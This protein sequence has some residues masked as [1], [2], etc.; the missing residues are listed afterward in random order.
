MKSTT[1]RRPQAVT[2]ICGE[3]CLDEPVLFV[4]VLPEGTVCFHAVPELRTGTRNRA[5]EPL[6][7]ARP[8]DPPV[9]RSGVMQ[10]PPREIGQRGVLVLTCH[11]CRLVKVPV[12]RERL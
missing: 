1:D 11:R 12:T 4:L 8:G 3:R 10:R 7:L 2:F 5:R 9:P 6:H